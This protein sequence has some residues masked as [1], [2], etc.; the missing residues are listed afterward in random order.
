[1]TLVLF[2]LFLVWGYIKWCS[3]TFSSSVLRSYFLLCSEDCMEDS[4]IIL[5]SCKCVLQFLSSL[6]SPRANY[7]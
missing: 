1:M 2:I 5:G 6:R 3:G 4:E 7:I